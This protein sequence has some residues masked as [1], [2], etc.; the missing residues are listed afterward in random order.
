MSGNNVKSNDNE[1][2]LTMIRNNDNKILENWYM[3]DTGTSSHMVKNEEG[4]KIFSNATKGGR[5]HE[6]RDHE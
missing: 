3:A 6:S 4:I 1:M 5:F 2:V